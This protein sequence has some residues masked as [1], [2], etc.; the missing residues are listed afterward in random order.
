[1]LPGGL[2]GATGEN[3]AVVAAGR[4]EAR[5]GPVLAVLCSDIVASTELYVALGDV[6]AHAMI[7]E[8]D[9]LTRRVL[10]SCGGRRVKGL[11]D[12]VL[13]VFRS[14]RAAIEAAIEL[15]G[16]A[17]DAR[18]VD[19]GGGGGTA[20]S[21]VI[22]I[23]LSAGEV[24]EDDEDDVHGAAV[25]TAARITALANAGQVL[26]AEIVV[27]LAGRMPG[28]EVRSLGARMLKGF[29]HPVEL[30][31]VRA[32]EQASDTGGG[33]APLP[34]VALSVAGEEFVGVVRPD[35]T[36]VEQPG[37]ES[38]HESR[39]SIPAP[40]TGLIGRA[41]D[42][43]GVSDAMRR[44]RLV[45]LTG[46]GGVGKTRMAIELG[47][48]R[49]PRSTDGVWMVDLAP[50]ATA[51]VPAATARVF[52]VR[53]AP[54]AGSTEALQRHVA[55]RDA[56]LV[57]D[58]CEH[59]LDACA[60]LATALLGVCPNLRIL[61]TSREPL[62]VA[63][64]TV[65][66]LE[67][68]APG[69]GFRLFVERARQRRADLVPDEDTDQA[70]SDI[71]ARL[72]HLPLG[73]ELAAARVSMMSPQEIDA[74][75]DAHFAEL[76]AARRQAPAR[77]RSVRAA[78]EWSYQ[79]LDDLEQ[80]AL[81][82]SAVFVGGFD[83]DAA[84]A[85]APGMTLDVLARL[86]DKSLVAVVLA[87]PRTRY[88]LL[89]TVREYASEQLV[90]ANEMA[91]ARARHLQHFSTIGIPAEAGWMSAG[92]LALLDERAAD[93]GNVRAAVEWA[94]ASEPCSAMRL[95]V[96]T[97]DLFFMLGQADGR[98]L[99]ELVLQ[100]CPERNRDRAELKIA[101]GQFAYLLGDM[102]AAND[103][104]N[105]AAAMS[106]ALGERSA[107]GTAYWFL[108]L[109]HLFGGAPDKGR[110]Y[111][112]VA[113]AIQ[114]ETG[115]L[116]GEARSTAAL[117]LTFLLDDD[118][119][120][121]RELVETALAIGVAAQDRWSQGQANLYLG[122]LAESSADP[123][124]AS[125]FFREA[126]ECMRLYRDSTLLPV[127]LIGQASVT[128]GHDPATALKVVAAAWAVR[129]RNGG[130]FAPFFRAF[131]ERVRATAAKG[132]ASDADR[133]WKDGSRLTVD[134][135]IALAF[136]VSRPRASPASAS[137]GVSQRELEVARLVAD[138][139][140]NKEIASRLHLSVRTVE[141]HV[142]HLLTK[143]G[144]VNRTQL[145]T[146]A[147]NRGA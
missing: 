92:V 114:Q 13:A 100:R 35:P 133:L 129:A 115:D 141:S 60:D 138:G 86:V 91:S 59:V 135:A 147:R 108:G 122:I 142:R 26:A 99:A 55:D 143:T 57:L 96:R 111:L 80:T 33:T 5:G 145:A 128:A 42:V 62:N 54:G 3:G 10:A 112:S 140:A 66:K 20:S 94:A 65:W 43:D 105:E 64:E 18:Q 29:D 23:G 101:A 123:Q 84:H 95:L 71:C 85:V 52:D 56:L 124:A 90:A 16:A 34:P 14:P 134:D 116:L 125:S 119:A 41:A 144:L 82:S 21:L 68:L 39:S 121:A 53:A 74:S 45:T 78:V 88:R 98:R 75:L 8:H 51:D 7:A 49:P 30:C 11:G 117:G 47:H 93:Y 97:R 12:G 102:P 48:R 9:E 104:L 120:R 110:G 32:E 1:M 25:V 130:E 79:L 67:P 81:R 132:V 24:V 77:H 139:L 87:R 113:Q 63:G 89:E 61:A 44:A 118:P 4:G 83:A 22:R 72:D 131:A 73:I 27:R 58:N 46:P 136:G 126:V 76:S 31:D 69:D 146:W 50:V 137:L 40:L 19:E 107:E 109:Q 28:V 103:L 6:A 127:A 2:F 70:I 36:I 38:G 37:D 106:A 15:Q 17:A